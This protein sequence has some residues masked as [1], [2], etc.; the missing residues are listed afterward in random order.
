VLSCIFCA[1][2]SFDHI[3]FMN[4][5]SCLK[6]K[7]KTRPSIVAHRGGAALRPENAMAAFIKA[8]Q[9]GAEE[10]E[11][12]VHRMKDG[13]GIVLHDFALQQLTGRPGCAY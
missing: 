10:I 7:S 4:G 12:D 5:V 9:L 1:N 3:V 6:E 8:M 13:K 11:W 2:V